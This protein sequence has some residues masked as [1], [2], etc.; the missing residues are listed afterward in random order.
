M[1][2][3]LV[4]FLGEIFRA[5]YADLPSPIEEDGAFAIVLDRGNK[6]LA[7]INGKWVD[8]NNPTDDSGYLR[9]LLNA[10]GVQSSVD[11]VHLQT[12]QPFTVTGTT[13][14]TT[15]FKKTFP[16][17]FFKVNDL[18]TVS[19]QGANNNNANNKS[20][21]VYINGNQ[22]A[23]FTLTTNTTCVQE[24]KYGIVSNVLVK[25]PNR[26]GGPSFGNGFAGSTKE[27]AAINIAAPIAVEIRLKLANAADTITLDQA[28]IAT[29]AGVGVNEA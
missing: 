7:A 22:M 29:S 2:D 23:D 10:N 18:I 6:L 24:I 8:P 20:Y 4:K 27:E 28:R 14:E 5:N 19:F 21:F 16:A 9:G 15:V 11:L 26:Y 12:S 1:A 17:N 3:K 25:G 13:T